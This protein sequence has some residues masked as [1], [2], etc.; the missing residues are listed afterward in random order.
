[1]AF[2]Y[3]YTYYVKGLGFN[4]NPV[5]KYGIP[6]YADSRANPKVVGTL[7]W[8][9]WW[10]EMTHYL[11]NGYESGSTFITPNF[12]WYLNFCPIA[13]IGRGFHLPEYVDADKELFDKYAYVKRP[14]VRKGI[15][16]LK[17][18]RGGLSEKGA[19]GILGY[20]MYMSIEKYNAALVAGLDDYVADMR[21][22][23]RELN[24][25]VPPELRVRFKLSDTDDHIMEG[26]KNE[27]G[28]PEGSQNSLFMR[29]M[30]NNPNVLKGKFLNDV[31][32]EEAGEFKHLIKGVTATMAGLKV[33]LDLI[34]TP[35]IYGTSGKSG[36]K[37]F[38]A[39]WH[40]ADHYGL[41]RHFLPGYRLV[42]GG[43]A[44]SRGADG[45]IHEDIP[46]LKKFQ[47]ENKLEDEQILGCE[48]VVRNDEKILANRK[49]L[50]NASNPELLIEHF[51]DFP[52]TIK[53]ALMSVATNH[54]DREAVASQQAFLMQQVR[55][56]FGKYVFEDVKDEEGMLVMPRQ[57][58]I[59]EATP[60]DRKE[61]IV[62]I[63]KGFEHPL[64]EKGYRHAYAAGLDSYDQ[65]V[66]LSSKSLGAMV[67][68]LRK[69]HPYRNE[70][71]EPLGNK[72]IPVM[73]IRNRPRRKEKF[74][75]NC[76]K[77]SIYWNLLGMTMIDAG[78]PAVIE[79]YKA[80][81]GR[82]FLASRPLSFESEDST[83][84]HDYG[85]LLTGS[86][87]SK[88]QMLSVLQ[89]WV[90]DEIDECVFPQIVDGL[91]S[92]NEE[93]D[94]SDWDEVDA[95]GL[96]LVCDIDKRLLKSKKEDPEKNEEKEWVWDAGAGTFRLQ[97]SKPQPKKTDLDKQ[98]TLSNTPN[99]VFM[100][101]LENGFLE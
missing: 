30:F 99:D 25:L 44:G 32:F 96:S 31:L 101:M 82:Q 46:N 27:K 17:K 95:L 81:G 57:V 55:D 1:M 90:I 15:I 47:E 52:R 42:I 97:S 18:R 28:D 94:D 79:Y 85:M 76:L 70:K 78:K 19:K 92:Y 72:R 7:A 9:Q 13:T 10:E 34:G 66:S 53:E 91:G 63:R 74:Y 98:K 41:V 39:L 2:D 83:Q 5:G 8:Q 23:F 4:P 20:G 75:D 67:V 22:K 100:R 56:L 68:T 51:L 6:K 11:V 35:I 24:T 40:D 36:S 49:D 26:W 71:N 89:P 16:S 93:E 43:F 14:D 12:F 62:F 3:E 84:R 54:F 86:K 50:E 69:G 87:K 37:D 88:P 29:T 65:D 58:Y 61:D 77:A 45:Q 33:G 59:R 73:L 64:H 38:R 21:M 80:N 60:A 48:D